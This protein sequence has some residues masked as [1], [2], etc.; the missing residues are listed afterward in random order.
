M[1]CAF[2]KGDIVTKIQTNLETVPEGGLLVLM[3]LKYNVFLDLIFFVG[4]FNFLL[5]FSI[6]QVNPGLS[7]NIIS[8]QETAAFSLVSQKQ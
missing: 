5:A 8:R 4:F 1:G 2:R 3:S 7:S 6:L